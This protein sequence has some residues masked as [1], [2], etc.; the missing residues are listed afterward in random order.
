MKKILHSVVFVVMFLMT[1]TI[2]AQVQHQRCG[3]KEEDRQI[4]VEQLLRNKAILASRGGA[5]ATRAVIYVPVIFHLVAKTDGT[6]RMPEAKVMPQLCALNEY[7]RDQEI[8]FYLRPA[9][10]GNPPGINYIDNDGLY[11]NPTSG[12]GYTISLQ[13]KKSDA[14]N[15][16]VNNSAAGATAYYQNTFNGL[17][18]SADWIVSKQSGISSDARVIAH[19]IG[20]FF[21]LPHTHNGWDDT[22]LP[23]GTT[24]A[25]A[26]SPR[27]TPTENVTRDNCATAGDFFCDTPADYNGLNASVSGACAGNQNWYDPTGVQLKANNNVM[28]YFYN[29]STF[30]FSAQQKAVINVDLT[31]NPNRAYLRRNVTPSLLAASAVPTLIAPLDLAVQPHYDYVQLSWNPVPNAEGYTIEISPFQT[32]DFGLISIFSPTSNFTVNNALIRAGQTLMVP[33]R[34]YYWRIR[35]FT[36]YTSVAAGC[37]QYSANGSFRTGTTIGTQELEGVKTFSV[38]PNPIERGQALNIEISMQSS[39]EATVRLTDIAGKTIRSEKRTFAAG[40]NRFDWRIEDLSAGM[41]I[42]SV[43]NAEGIASKKVVVTN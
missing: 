42:L 27:G 10:G 36:A 8:Q 19:E 30:V 7:F 5:L 37:T 35:P 38:S 2:S 43:E 33:N 16:Y 17:R 4:I 3:L 22:P 21:A 24:P 14:I 34:N 31:T 26:V 13:N 18:Y 12:A 1:A 15:I 25:P 11:S 32:F 40:T 6:G 28:S 9:E 29:C 39:L 20:H 41:Y 23:F